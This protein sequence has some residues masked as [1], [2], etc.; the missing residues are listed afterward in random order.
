MPS[1]TGSNRPGMHC[2]AGLPRQRE[3]FSDV[4]SSISE[5]LASL[6]IRSVEDVDQAVPDPQSLT[7][8]DCRRPRARAAKSIR[9]EQATEY[10]AT[11]EDDPFGPSWTQSHDPP[12]AP[13]LRRGATLR[14]PGRHLITPP[15]ACRSWRGGRTVKPIGRIRPVTIPSRQPNLTRFRNSRVMEGMI[16]GQRDLTA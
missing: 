14:L 16:P 9:T 6:C 13:H 5:K 1:A 7:I 12:A 10:C 3:R 11:A 8:G 15:S 4:K 2:S